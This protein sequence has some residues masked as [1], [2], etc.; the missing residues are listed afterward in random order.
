VNRAEG[1]E[2]PSAGAA[3]PSA[4]EELRLLRTAELAAVAARRRP[5]RG[6]ADGTALVAA[7]VVDAVALLQAC[8]VPAGIGGTDAGGA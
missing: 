4:D 5:W 3:R 1:L 8:E 7:S 2:A 6:G